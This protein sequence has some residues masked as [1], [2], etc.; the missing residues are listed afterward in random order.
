MN[1]NL[2]IGSYADKTTESEMIKGGA[3]VSS[4]V[5]LQRKLLQG[6]ESDGFIFDSIAV[7]PALPKVAKGKRIEFSV[8]PR[9]AM[10]EDIIIPFVNFPIIHRFEK[11]IGLKREI[12][13]WMRRTNGDNI[14]IYSL[15]SYLL[16]GGVFAK[17]KYKKNVIVIVPD[18]PE[19]MSNNKSLLYKLLKKI[20]RKIINYCLKRLDSM[21]LF[22]EHMKERLPIQSKRF[23]VM[24]GVLSINDCKYLQQVNNRFNND[25]KVIM[26]TG[27]LDIEDGVLELLKAFSGI[28]GAGYS[29]WI[30]GTGNAHSIINQYTRKDPRIKYFGYIESYEEFLSIQCRAKVFA[31]MVEPSHPK[32]SFY[33]PSKIMEYLVTGGI[34]LCNKLNCIPDEYDKYLHYFDKNNKTETIKKLLDIGRD[35]VKAEALDRIC[36]LHEKTPDKQAKKIID[37]L[38]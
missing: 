11:I 33:F 38:D 19:Y 8:E 26:L 16:L 34:V 30:T 4:S 32:S 1:R 3:F 35:E 28:D 2:W 14:V 12:K 22:S 29:L 10:A 20:D 21:V 31:L 7:Y 9:S 27:N 36:F 24:E 18:L 5:N 13:N 17:K 6:L 37:L 23:R 25:E 15:A